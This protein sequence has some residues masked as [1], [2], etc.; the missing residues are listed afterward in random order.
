MILFDIDENCRDVYGVDSKVIYII[1]LLGFFRFEW[2]YFLHDDVIIC[3]KKEWWQRQTVRVMVTTTFYL[4]SIGFSWW[5]GILWTWISSVLFH[6]SLVVINYTHFFII[7]YKLHWDCVIEREL[8]QS[9][10]FRYLY[11]HVHI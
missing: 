1:C 4:L 5:Y 3:L 2:V 7:A 6:S 9:I 10:Y 11:L 8:S